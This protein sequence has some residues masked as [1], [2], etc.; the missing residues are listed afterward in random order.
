MPLHRVPKQRSH[1]GDKPRLSEHN[2][3]EQLLKQT[4][5]YSSTA[6]Y[7]S[8]TLARVADEEQDRREAEVQSGLDTLRISVE[9]SVI[10]NTQQLSTPTETLRRRMRVFTRSATFFADAWVRLFRL[11]CV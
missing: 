7:D 9:Y 8:E 11:Q 4:G 3:N 1:P 10:L 2:Q 5:S 6:T